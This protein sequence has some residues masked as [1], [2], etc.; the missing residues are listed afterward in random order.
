MSGGKERKILGVL[1]FFS[2]LFRIPVCTV[3]LW[4]SGNNNKPLLGLTSEDTT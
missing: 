4:P 1:A 2:C 3:G